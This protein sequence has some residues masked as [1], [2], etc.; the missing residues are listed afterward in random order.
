MNRECIR[1]WRAGRFQ[2]DL[3]D[4]GSC[5][6]RGQTRLA[7]T[8]RDNGNVIFE[9]DDFAGSPLHADDS[10]ETVAALLSF[11]SLRPGDTDREYFDR[12]TPEQLEWAQQNGEELSLLAHEMEERAQRGMVPCEVE[13]HFGAWLVTFDGGETLLLQTDYD[14]AAFAVSCGAIQAPAEWDGLPSK[15]GKDWACFDPSTID[16]CPDEYLD[17]AEPGEES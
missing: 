5:D 6:S 12:Y 9:G 3:F 15:L 17:V 4:T 2:L 16:G 11:L 8:F 1:T 7:Y 10:E 14:Q 13:T